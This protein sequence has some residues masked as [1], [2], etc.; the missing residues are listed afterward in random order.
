MTQ[1]SQAALVALTVIFYPIPFKT[2]RN[3]DLRARTSSTMVTCRH[4]QWVALTCMQGDDTNSVHHPTTPS[5]SSLL[6]QWDLLKCLWADFKWILKQHTFCANPLVACC[7]TMQDYLLAVT[8]LPGRS[9]RENKM[10]RCFMVPGMAKW[11]RQCCFRITGNPHG[12]YTTLNVTK[13]PAAL[14]YCSLSQLY[15]TSKQEIT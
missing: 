15:Q 1:R 5:W 11:A 9:D 14:A 7:K 3:H 6:S 4:L 12:P 10:I 13:G 8:G 2:K